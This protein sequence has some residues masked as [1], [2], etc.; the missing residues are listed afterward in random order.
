MMNINF[1]EERGH[2]LKPCETA[3]AK[4]KFAKLLWVT[5]SGA[6]SEVWGQITVVSMGSDPFEFTGSFHLVGDPFVGVCGQ[7][8]KISRS[9]QS[10][11][12]LKEDKGALADRGYC[13]VPADAESLI[14]VKVSKLINA[15]F[16]YG[17]HHQW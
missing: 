14:P 3:P 11:Y 6:V 10:L 15:R 7:F 17:K 16:N 8:C 13:F 2:L 9:S 1:R 12:C 4:G 5:K